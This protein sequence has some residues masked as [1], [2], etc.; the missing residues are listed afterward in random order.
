MLDWCTIASDPTQKPT[1]M[2]TSIPS[3]IPSAVPSS[4]PSRIPTTEPSGLP[5]KIPTGEPTRF[6]SSFPTTVPSGLP[7]SVPS[8]PTASPTLGDRRNYSVIFEVASGSSN[9]DFEIFVRI[10]GSYEINDDTDISEWTDWVSIKGLSE[11][12]QE[13]IFNREFIAD[14]SQ[15]INKLTIL[16]F[17]TNSYLSIE[18]FGVSTSS[19]QQLYCESDA[20]DMDASSSN[21]DSCFFV[22]IDFKTNTSI[23]QTDSSCRYSVENYDIYN[24]TSMTTQASTATSTPNVE[25]TAE[26]MERT[27][28]TTATMTTTT[29]TT[30]EETNVAEAN[31]LG[32]FSNGIVIFVYGLLIV[33]ILFMLMAWVWHRQKGKQSD[34]PVLLSF[35]RF[36]TSVGDF[37][38]DLL[39]MVV[40]IF[41][42]DSGNGSESIRVICYLAIVFT[43]LPFTLSC[44]F[45]VYQTERWKIRQNSRLSDWIRDHGVVIF[46]L[47]IIA[48]F[49]TAVEL[50][51]SKAFYL[52]MFHFPLKRDEYQNLKNSQ[53]LLV[54]VLENIPQL[55][56][57]MAYLTI[58]TDSSDNGLNL[59]AFISMVFSVLSIISSIMAQ[60]S[61]ICQCFRTRAG[62][63]GYNIT[64]NGCLCLKSSSLKH[65][66]AFAHNKIRRCIFDTI[67][68]TDEGALKQIV[69]NSR[70]DVAFSVEVFY[71]EDHISTMKELNCYF[72]IEILSHDR[73]VSKLFQNELINMVTIIANAGP[74]TAAIKLNKSL[75]RS[76]K[77]DDVF[78]TME[79]I[80]ATSK[81][82]ISDRNS[83]LLHQQ[84]SM[85]SSMASM[86]ATSSRKNSVPAPGSPVGDPV[87]SANITS[88]EM[89]QLSQTSMNSMNKMNGNVGHEQATPKQEFLLQFAM[90]DTP[91]QV[92]GHT[93]QT[94]QQVNST[95]TNGLETLEETRSDNLNMGESGEDGHDVE[96]DLET[97]I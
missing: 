72:E 16:T 15:N 24:S 41:E 74:T 40:L 37:W 84:L 59:I 66:H 12:N 35:V 32:E 97:P 18:C 81:S 96:N 26:K 89:S 82:L 11:N 31:S 88:A 20:I 61:R 73:N 58:K 50:V 70:S 34:G 87:L 85:A 17:E 57:Q 83:V 23:A 38:T 2:P 49:H 22:E 39:F 4:L 42:A 29:K 67:Q 13:Y 55:C 75:K 27:S 63:Y 1:S 25:S 77:L 5:T 28:T 69:R 10:Q 64:I 60:T 93:T 45:A 48:G 46:G 90:P 68:A 47:T 92:E 91:G 80:V 6:P 65:V 62:K 53:F 8:E 9:D 3:V 76:L 79:D 94:G 33:M 52:K 44:C 95:M 36:G 51:R 30:E 7:T 86:S 21:S 54:V 14:V 56:I 19:K 78:C 43:I 71:F